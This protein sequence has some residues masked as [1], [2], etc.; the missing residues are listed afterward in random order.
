MNIENYYTKI[1]GYTLG[2]FGTLF[3]AALFYR[4]VQYCFGASPKAKTEGSKGLVNTAINERLAETPSARFVREVETIWSM[5]ERDDWL[6]RRSLV[7]TM[8]SRFL[9]GSPIPKCNPDEKDRLRRIL[10]VIDHL[11]AHAT[12]LQSPA[13]EAVYQVIA[14]LNRILPY[15]RKA[16]E[17]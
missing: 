7:T 2:V 9:R 13:N 12:L 11:T 15:I 10:V 14:D 5:T 4:M 3:I 16:I 8:Q 17:S 6:D 1:V